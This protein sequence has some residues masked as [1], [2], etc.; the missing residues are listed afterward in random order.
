M[1]WDVETCEGGGEEEEEVEM[2][3][4]VVGFVRLLAFSFCFLLFVFDFSLAF[5]EFR[6]LRFLFLVPFLL[7]FLSPFVFAFSCL[8][9]FVVP[10]YTAHIT[11]SYQGFSKREML[12]QTCPL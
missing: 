10:L 4:V 2:G 7:S 8:L 9:L 11:S 3:E 1:F 5:R 6:F 12:S